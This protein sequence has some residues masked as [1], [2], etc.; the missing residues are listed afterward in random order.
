M[1]AALEVT[2][3][4]DESLGQ[5]NIF[6]QRKI[7]NPSR[8]LDRFNAKYYYH[9]I[10]CKIYLLGKVWWT[11]LRLVF[12]TEDNLCGD[13]RSDILWGGIL[14]MRALCHIWLNTLTRLS[15]C[16]G[17]V[18]GSLSRMSLFFRIFLVVIFSIFSG[19][20]MKIMWLGFVSGQTEISRTY[21]IG[22]LGLKREAAVRA[23]LELGL[24][25][26]ITW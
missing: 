6:E 12:V 3:Y 10:K 19:T 16:G 11:K 17:Y 13:G 23:H 15:L 26:D 21:I 9:I 14:L 24:F 7:F 2:S 5:T 20:R 22:Q 25:F 4:F 1:W 8:I 18:V